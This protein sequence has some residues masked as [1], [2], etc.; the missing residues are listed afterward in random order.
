MSLEELRERNKKLVT[1][2][3]LE[4]F[5]ESGIDKTK[6]SDI[7]KRAGLTERSVYRYF[8][9][10]TDLLIAAS[11]LYW[12]KAEKYTREALEK[13]SRPGMTGIEQISVILHAYSS[14]LLAD[15][16]GI[17]FSL[18]AEVALYNAGKTHEVVNRP[19]EKYE[20][21]AGPLAQAVQVGIADGTVNPDANIKQ[22]Y[23]NSYDSIL[24]MMQR[25]TV[26]VPSV[27][28]LDTEDRLRAI[29]DMYVQ[30]FAAKK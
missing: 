26:G 24:G 13:V 23:Y 19:P 6:I 12:D 28:E 4:C 16:Q 14:I 1:E 20:T 22:L 30:E 17:R 2:K 3:A 8:A 9:T 27:T 7:A 5:I 29:C 21:Y 11:F 10:K 25:L 18:D 15:P